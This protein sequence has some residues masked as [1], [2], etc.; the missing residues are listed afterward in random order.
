MGFDIGNSETAIFP[1]IVGDDYKVREACRMLHEN[2]IYVNPVQ[3]PAVPRRL[4]RIRISLMSAHTREHLD[5]TLN[6]LEDVSKKL[7]IIK[8]VEYEC[9]TV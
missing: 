3:Y 6:V 7:N 2:N 9:C 1:I 4:A 5:K 8:E